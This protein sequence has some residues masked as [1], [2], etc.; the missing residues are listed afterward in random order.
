MTKIELEKL[1]TPNQNLKPWLGE[2]FIEVWAALPELAYER[3]ETKAGKPALKF[4]KGLDYLWVPNYYD[5]Q[6]EFGIAWNDP[7]LAI[8]WGISEPIISARDSNNPFLRQIPED[9]LP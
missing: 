3:T 4:E 9:M 8:D 2:N 7:D 1:Y 6:D 5:G